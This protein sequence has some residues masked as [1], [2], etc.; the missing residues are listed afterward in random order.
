MCGPQ[1]GPSKLVTL[2][3][4]TFRTLILTPEEGLNRFIYPSKSL[5]TA[6]TAAINIIGIDIRTS[7]V[8]PILR[9]FCCSVLYFNVREGIAAVI[10]GSMPRR[11]S[12]SA[13]LTIPLGKR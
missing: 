4:L 9:Y 5:H 3:G 10:P 6:S 2:T 7:T 13:F 8:F 12:A 11:S 1:G